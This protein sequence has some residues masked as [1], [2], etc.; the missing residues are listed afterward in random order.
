[1]GGPR[2]ARLTRFVLIAVVAALLAAGCGGDRSPPAVPEDPRRPT[3]TIASFNFAESQI[4]AELYAQALRGRGYPVEVVAAVGAREIVEPALEQGKTDLVPEYM[5]TA[6]DFLNRG[7]RVAT[8]DPART[9]QLLRRELARRG[10][11]V[12]EY[13]PVEN[14][15]GYVVTAATARRNG[16]RRISDLSSLAS[17]LTFGGPPECPARPLCL[18]G[19]EDLYGLRFARFQP[20]PSREVTAVALTT[21]EIDV[22][23][24]ET[25]DGSLATHDLVQLEDDRRLQPAENIVPAVRTQV[26]RAY[27][28]PLAGVLNAVTRALVTPELIGMNRRVQQG[29]EPAA[30]V[31]ADWL[32]EH[33]LG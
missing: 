2:T 13:A 7:E 15:N 11:T 12:L 32:R 5:G 24:I 4:L 22:G 30:A 28:E 17:R 14:R 3:V 29:E 20:M 1:M 18:K 25:T 19:L 16:L 8:A 10:V 21:R 33:H 26:L 31:A 27:G 9:Y 23:M 6:L